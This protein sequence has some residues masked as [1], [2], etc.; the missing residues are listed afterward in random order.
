[1]AKIF[2]LIGHCFYSNK[3]I[4]FTISLN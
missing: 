3:Q 4:L 2:D 1:L